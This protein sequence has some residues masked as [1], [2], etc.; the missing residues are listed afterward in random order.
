MAPASMVLHTLVIVCFMSAMACITCHLKEQTTGLRLGFVHFRTQTVKCHI[1]AYSNFHFRTQLERIFGKETSFPLLDC[2]FLYINH[3]FDELIHLVQ[4]FFLTKRSGS[5][6]NFCTQSLQQKYTRLEGKCSFPSQIAK[7]VL[8]TGFFS[9]GQR[10]CMVG[11]GDGSTAFFSE[12]IGV[13]SPPP[14]P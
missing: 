2:I 6:L 9:T 5:L 12:C 14:P 8:S 10:I 3:R 11:R 4:F 7:I 13:D 1:A